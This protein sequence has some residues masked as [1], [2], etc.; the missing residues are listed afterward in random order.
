MAQ[1]SLPYAIDPRI[2]AKP[3]LPSHLTVIRDLGAT[4]IVNEIGG[5]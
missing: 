3:T 1:C 5:F 2:R 4:P